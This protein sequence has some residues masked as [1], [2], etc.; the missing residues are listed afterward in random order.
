MRNADKQT[1]T[2][3]QWLR[4]PALPGAS[5]PPALGASS[6]V[7]PARVLPAL[8]LPR[9]GVVYDLDPGRWPGMPVLP[10]HAPYTLATYRTPQGIGLAGD[11]PGFGEGPANVTFLSEMM[12]ASMHTGAHVDALSHIACGSDDHWYGGDRAA[13][14]LTDFGPRTADG[15]ALPP[16]LCRGVLVDLPRHRGVEALDAGTGVGWSEIEAALAADGVELRR[17]DAV[18][19]RT[20]LMRW[21]GRDTEAARAHADA[22]IDVEAASALAEAGV[23]MV[24]ADTESL[25]QLPSPEPG[26]PLP[27]H[28]RLLVEAGVHI[29][30]LFYLEDLAADDVHEFLFLCLPLRVRGATGSMVRPVAVS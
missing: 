6:S 14:E 19:I 5:A 15:A 17:G 18:L 23:L 28:V 8:S 25:E 26:N 4:Q 12:V 2:A 24:A 11:L 1:A 22:G 16:F 9:R 13:D 30:E 7:L 3:D 29:G 21:W 20:G 10:S 27:V